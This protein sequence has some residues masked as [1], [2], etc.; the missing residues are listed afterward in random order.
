MD[1]YAPGSS[2]VSL[3]PSGGTTTTSGT[4]MATPHVAGVAALYK[5]AFGDVSAAALQTWLT[6]NATPNVVTGS[7]SGTSNRLLFTNL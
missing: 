7:L 6:T 5:S 2:I 1:I 3:T 4:S